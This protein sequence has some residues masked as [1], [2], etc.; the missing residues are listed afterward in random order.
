VHGGN[1]LLYKKNKGWSKPRLLL[2]RRRVASVRFVVSQVL[3]N[4]LGR[5]EKYQHVQ[6]H[7]NGDR[8]G[9]TN[10]T[11]NSISRCNYALH[12]EIKSLMEAGQ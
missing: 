12:Q 3:Y 8:S 2:K 1:P 4:P 11:M 5:T 6:N 7:G 9:Q 10:G